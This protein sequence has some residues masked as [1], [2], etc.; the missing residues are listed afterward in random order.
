MTDPLHGRPETLQG[1][2]SGSRLGGLPP[3]YE[4][5]AAFN[6]PMFVRPTI[7]RLLAA[8]PPAYLAGLDAVVLRS[9]ESLSGPERRRKTRGRGRAVLLR[10]CLG[11]YHRARR[12][13]P[14]S[15]ELIVDNILGSMPRW[16]LRVPCL[17]ETA[18][19][20]VLYHELGH[21]IHSLFAP[22]YRKR[23]QVAEQWERRLT[24]RYL[25]ANYWYLLPLAYVLRGPLR[26]V[27]GSLLRLSHTRSRS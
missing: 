2:A 20:K 15:I 10:D 7:G 8:L 17:R 11:I 14:A 4:H 24:R 26:I 27:R 22:E 13:R 18:I 23:E 19:G 25:R 3:V 5:Y 9:T 1:I 21:H 6:P 16:F 12:G